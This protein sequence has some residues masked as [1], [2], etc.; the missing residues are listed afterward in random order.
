MH[1]YALV[2]AV[3]SP[4]VIAPSTAFAAQPDWWLIFGSGD[5]PKRQVIYA[6]A[7]SVADTPSKSGAEPTRSVVVVY[8]FEDKD[9]PLYAMYTISFQCKAGRYRVEAANAQMP[10]GEITQE[11]TSSQWAPAARSVMERPYDF[12]C[13]ASSRRTNGMIK[14]GRRE[15]ANTLP[16]F[17]Y[18]ALWGLATNVPG[19]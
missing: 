19:Q 7:L 10:S 15:L 11:P 17:T 1:R 16:E 2:L 12:V 14:I 4:L 13:N 8:V 5:K 9:K 6:D 3:L 18:K